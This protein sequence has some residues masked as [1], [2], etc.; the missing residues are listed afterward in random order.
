[1][2]GHGKVLHLVSAIY[3]SLSFDLTKVYCRIH[4]NTDI[5]D[6]KVIGKTSDLI[7]EVR[8]NVWTIL[9]SNEIHNMAFVS[10]FDH[11][12]YNIAIRL[13][14][15]L[16]YTVGADRWSRR[17]SADASNHDNA[18]TLA[19]DESLKWMT[20]TDHTECVDIHNLKAW[21]NKEIVY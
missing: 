5:R 20:H 21:V 2:N 16:G 13:E 9:S 14:C 1:M 19:F 4:S 10:E 18:T 7:S 12:P 17:T 8:F 15:M 6:Y 3:F 11:L